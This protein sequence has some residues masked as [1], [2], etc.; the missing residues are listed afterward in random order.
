[1][2]ELTAR[3][4]DQL[5]WREKAIIA[6]QKGDKTAATLLIHL[7]QEIKKTRD[8]IAVTEGLI[9][10]RDKAAAAANRT[11]LAIQKNEAE[12]AK[13]NKQLTQYNALLD[14]T[15]SKGAKA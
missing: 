3:L 11:N 13:V 12:L 1:M 14:G 2:S 5:S 8:L 6:Q 15:A 7:D 9:A 4:A 10:E